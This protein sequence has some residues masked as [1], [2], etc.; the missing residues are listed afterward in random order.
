MPIVSSSHVVGHAQ[1]DGRQYVTET[2]TDDAG[3]VL[4]VEYLA[5]A[6][7]DHTAIRNARVAAMNEQLAEAEAQALIDGGA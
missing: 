5:E 6:G 1:R 2:H 7:A 3:A 4:V